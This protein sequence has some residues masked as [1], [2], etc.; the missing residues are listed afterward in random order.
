MR[1]DAPRLMV[2]APA[3]GSGKTT[4]VCALLRAFIRRGRRCASFKCGPDY[5]DPMFHRESVGTCRSANLDLF[6][7]GGEGVRRLLAQGSRGM[8]LSVLEGV[9]GYYDGMATGTDASSWETARATETP[10]VLLVNGRGQAA[11]LAA[12]VSGF[13]RFRPDSGIRA[14]VLNNVSAGMAPFLRELLEREC[15]IPV[16][17]FLPPMGDCS[18]ESRHLG[19]VTAAE[20]ADLAAKL[21]ALAEQAE[22]TVDLDFLE[23]LAGEAPPL[24]YAPIPRERRFPVRVAVARD[25]AFCFYY[26]ESL[27][28]LEELGA[29]LIPFS[30]LSDAALPE[31]DALLLGGG[32]PEL[33]AKALADNAS[34]RKSV[35][36]ALRGGMPAIAECGGFLYLHETLEGD[37]GKKYPMCGVIPAAAFRTEKLR[38]FGYINMTARRD[39]LLC[40][41]GGTLR[42]H[43][44]HYWDSEA[45]GDGFSAA[46][47][48]RD[49]RWDC[50]YIS[51]TLYAGFPHLYL[52]GAPEA[53]ARF[54][55]AAERRKKG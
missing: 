16:A 13:L 32:Y 1:A 10:A 15:G 30:P 36:E 37:D 19:L 48:L 34:M 44:F 29:E 25:E 21:D 45:P 12:L 8:D 22:K 4:F 17:G 23:R 5:I 24:E 31:A 53:A 50:A 51:Q 2:A 47:P 11:S 28:L 3:S 35:A 7:S 14:V 9:M 55:S 39:N 33:H 52:A 26:G 27:A 54:L 38:R 43:E 20:T 46:K 41:A 42:A 6:F 18:L 40:P 49:T